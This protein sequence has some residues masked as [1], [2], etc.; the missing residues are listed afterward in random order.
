MIKVVVLFLALFIFL[1]PLIGCYN[2]RHYDKQD[3]APSITVLVGDIE[4]EWTV[5]L[6]EWNGRI[7]DR[8]CNFHALMSRITVEDLVYVRNGETITIQFVGKAPN[9]YRLT[10]HILRETG[11]RKYSINGMEYD[12]SFDKNN[13]TIFTIEPNFAT[14]LSSNGMD[15]E[16]GNTIKGYLLFARWGDNTCEYGFIIRGDAAITISREPLPSIS[17]LNVSPSGLSFVL[18]NPTDNEIIFGEDYS[19]LVKDNNIWE[20][21]I[22]IIEDWGFNDVANILAPNETSVSMD[23]NWQWL[24]G[25][26]PAGNYIFRKSVIFIRSPGDYDEFIVEQQ[27]TIG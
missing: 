24:F 8:I 5:G 3:E 22:P 6:N 17:I 25:E 15:Y 4:I 2:Q 19:L 10:E 21:V 13:T 7:Y 14:A 26:L 23:I 20:T 12:I 9:E 16:P 18:D 11:D 27:F 1:V